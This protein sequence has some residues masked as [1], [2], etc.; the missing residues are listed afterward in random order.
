MNVM[1]WIFFVFAFVL[2]ALL[3]PDVYRRD[4]VLITALH[5]N[6]ATKNV[7][8]LLDKEAILLR[9][10]GSHDFVLFFNAKKFNLDN[11]FEQIL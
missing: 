10:S 1:L 8:V 7:L 9:T 3:T 6:N 2:C 4:Y 5:R 11:R